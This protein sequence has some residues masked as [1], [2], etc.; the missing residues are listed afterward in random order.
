MYDIKQFKPALYV[1]VAL[2][3]TGFSLAAEAPG[4][5]LLAIGALGLNAWLVQTGRFR[6]MPRLI[7]NVVTLLAFFYVATQVRVLGPKAV[8]VIGQFLVLLQLIKLFEQ[9]ANRD[10]AQVLVLSLLL[11]VAASIS[12]AS[13]LFGVMMISYLFLSLYCCL[14]FHL[15]VE[16][17]H[18]QAA[19]AMP[20]ERLNP[21]T[22][23]QDQRYLSKSMRRLT[24]FV[25]L[26]SVVLAVAVFLFFP[27][28]TGAGLLGPLQFRQ[29][30]TLTGFSEQVGFQQVARITQSNEVVAH[31][32]LTKNGAPVEGPMLLML[33]GVT[34]DTY[35]GDGSQGGGAWQWSRSPAVASGSP[36]EFPANVNKPISRYPE[37]PNGDRWVQQF[38][39][40]PTGTNVL[41]AM[42]GPTHMQLGRYANLT[43]SRYDE[44]VRMQE[45][46][47]QP[48]QYTVTSRGS[49]R[50]AQPNPL[51]RR[52]VYRQRQREESQPTGPFGGFPGFGGG[53][54]GGP[55]MPDESIIHERVREYALRPEV[56]GAD[57]NGPLAPQRAAAAG[58]DEALAVTAHDEAIASAIEKHLQDTFAY[59][60]DLTDAARVRGE[61]PMVSFL[62]DLKRGH[63]EYFAGAMTLLCQSLG[64]HA[65]MV[66]G[67][68]CDEFNPMLGQYVVRQSHAHAWVEVL[69]PDGTWKTYDP[70]SARDPRNTPRALSPW[71]RVKQLFDYL[72]YTWAAN[73]VAYDNDSRENLVQNLDKRLTST[74]TTGKD[75]ATNFQDYLARGGDW[76]ATRVIG[77]IMVLMVLTL[78]GAVLWF[79]YER[80]QL[81]RRAERIGLEALPASE[82]LRLARQLGFYDDLVQLLEK[83]DIVRPKHLTPLEWAESLAFLPAEAHETIRRLTE[84]FY[85]IRFGHAELSSGQRHRLTNVLHRLNTCLA[86][87]K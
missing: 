18:A 75:I 3:I 42:A 52:D 21:N 27:R 23:R 26:V 78:I 22:L 84:I 15:K 12:T 83:R 48:I 6:P 34:L 59:T 44:S 76:I 1:L 40:Q 31:V 51:G 41:F 30:E 85:R 9:R 71:A 87:K 33:R 63:C 16:S 60:L 61:D 11:M 77:P 47:E 38:T 7:A 68:K 32:R 14:L 29:N 54:G 37:D 4:L 45:R 50:A 17:D 62:Y 80:W 55:A 86:P 5:W 81:R 70:T 36:D 64:V 65:R 56:S 58:G 35:H 19:I 72:E 13:L 79:L 73:V 25:S 49:L 69:M 82:K 10:Y 39:L 57:A 20:D 67:F 53:G 74:A 66:V 8:L 43:Y 28:G 2:G 24:G 46:I